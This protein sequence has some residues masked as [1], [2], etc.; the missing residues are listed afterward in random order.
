MYMNPMHQQGPQGHHGHQGH[1]VVYQSEPNWQ[2][3]MKHKRDA[4]MHALHPHMGRK[5]RVTTID[6]H[7]H[8][9]V[10]INS[11]GHH[12]YL[13]TDPHHG[14]HQ[15]HNRPIYTPAQYNQI[16]TL[17]LFELLVI[18]LLA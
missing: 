7:T 14:H 5:I 6:G 9:G 13:N 4:V 1:H 15:G 2:H 18:L 17:V 16:I 3:M 12:V 8:E 10:L 11:D